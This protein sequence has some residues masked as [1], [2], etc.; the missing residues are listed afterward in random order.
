MFF[1]LFGLLIHSASVDISINQER[2]QEF[3]GWRPSKMTS[4][5][6]KLEL[7]PEQEPPPPQQQ[8]E[9]TILLSDTVIGTTTTA[10]TASAIS[11]AVKASKKIKLDIAPTL[12]P[13]DLSVNFL[14]T[15]PWDQDM[16]LFPPQSPVTA[17]DFLPVVVMNKK[18]TVNDEDQ[19]IINGDQSTIH[20]RFRL[21]PI[22]GAAQ[23][24][25]RD[26][27]AYQIQ[28]WNA[29]DPQE[30]K[31]PL[32]DSGKV[33]IPTMPL[34]IPYTGQHPLPEGIIIEWNVQIWDAQGNGPFS[35]MQPSKFAVG[36]TRW[37][38][39]WI[40]LPSDYDTLVGKERHLFSNIH[41]ESRKGRCDDYHARLPLP[42]ARA[43]VKVVKPVHSALLVVSGLGSFAVSI[44][45]MPLSSSS[46]MDPP[47]TDFTQRVSYRGYD[48]TEYI[49]KDVMVV[50]GITLAS[51][52]WDQLPLAPKIVNPELMPQGIITTIAQ[53]HVSYQDGSSEILIPTDGVM[54]IQHNGT[55]PIHNTT[56]YAWQ[57]GKGF[58]QESNLYTGE[59]INLETMWDNLGWDTPQGLQNNNNNAIRWSDPM[60]YTTITTREEWHHK[61]QMGAY[62]KQAQV[63]SS[64]IAP[65]G[66][67]RPIQIP[68]VMPIAKLAPISVMDKGHGTLL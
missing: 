31:I 16:K 23:E 20:F 57:M 43:T 13:I 32:W 5:M 51:G 10:T 38:G 14:S 26:I 4:T 59:T 68:P 66:K 6:L 36:P 28:L 41:P 29:Y 65:I 49:R 35:A 12:R 58:I 63:I 50:V 54:E 34:S 18:W 40:V 19:V 30:N 21:Q 53:L 27:T 24:A 3:F 44:N 37:K 48:V 39:Q 17:E 60:L 42:L 61:L 56:S 9:P 45:G 47:L 11:T 46:V 62:D 7:T 2:T 55:A 25:I 22:P 15:I 8:Q 64:P 52:W 67:L 33:S 1:L